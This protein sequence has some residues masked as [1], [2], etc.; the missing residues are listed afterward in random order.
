MQ[1]SAHICILKT[2]CLQNKI[3]THLAPE[4][5]IQGPLT[6]VLGFPFPSIPSQ[7][8]AASITK[9]LLALVLADAA[10]PGEGQGNPLQ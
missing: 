9:Q 6:G 8:P 5:G 4:H 3:Q 2:L 7:A 1:H 10:S